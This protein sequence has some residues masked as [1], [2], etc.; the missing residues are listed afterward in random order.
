MRAYGKVLP[1]LR[2][3]RG[4][5]PSEERLLELIKDG[6][7][8]DPHR[9]GRGMDSEASNW[10]MRGPR[11]RRR[12]SGLV[13]Y[14][15]RTSRIGLRRFGRSLRRERRPE[16][17]R[18]LQKIRVHSIGDQDRTAGWVK[19]KS[20]GCVL[21]LLEGAFPRAFGRGGDQEIVS[22]RWLEEHV[23]NGHGP[24]GPLYPPKAAGEGR[25]QGGGHA[26]LLLRASQ[27][28]E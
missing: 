9:V 5:Y 20:S 13:H 11:P 22:R 25:R 6:H 19:K 26:V 14:L 21:D 27:R 23:L 12:A 10:I 7:N 16:L 1:N 17:A 4:D 3:H 24:L 2:K 15:G 28:P 18:F 8:G